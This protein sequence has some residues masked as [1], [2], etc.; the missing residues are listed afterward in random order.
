MPHFERMDG[1]SKA[2]GYFALFFTPVAHQPNDGFGPRETDARG[3]SARDLR[4]NTKH[5]GRTCCE[6][7]TR[8]GHDTRGLR[9]LHRWEGFI[10]TGTGRKG[11]HCRDSE[12]REGQ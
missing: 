1:T 8:T 2:A 4:A 6:G 11:G 10:I 7:L 9:V 5:A 3:I 12:E